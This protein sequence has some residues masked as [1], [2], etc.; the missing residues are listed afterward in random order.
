MINKKGFS[1]IR[2]NGTYCGVGF[3]C[4]RCD[5]WNERPKE[6]KSTYCDECGQ[7]NQFDLKK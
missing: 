6:V 2:I 1:D 5:S 4:V 7:L 3:N